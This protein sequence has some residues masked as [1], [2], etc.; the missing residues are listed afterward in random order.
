M[1]DHQASGSGGDAK[2]RHLAP[3]GMGGLLYVHI[4]TVREAQRGAWHVRV[5]SLGSGSSGNA[6]LVQTSRTA[7]LVD[8][9]FQPRTLSSRLRQAGV[10]PAMLSAILL[11][12]EHGD[13]AGGAAAFAALYGVPLVSDPRTLK[14][15]LTQQGSALQPVAATSVAQTELAVGRDIKIADLAVRSFPVSHDAV[16][17]CGYVLS[18]GAWT[19]VVVTDTGECIP[20]VV[21]ALRGAHLLVLEANHDKERL[22]SGPYP[23][24]LKRRILGSTGH[25]SNEQAAEALVQALDEGPRWIWLAHLSRTNNTPDLA[26]RQVRDYL[27]ARGLGHARLQVAPPGIGPQ[28]DSTALLNATPPLDSSDAGHP[29]DTAVSP[30]RPREPRT[31]V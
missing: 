31:E 24:H 25:L 12:H 20:P 26:R 8:A 30:A 17:P 7:V 18:T 9:G 6:L 4:L 2:E 10:T 27:W 11:T 16:A 3:G 23:W 28:W 22:L 1:D 21:E 13:H 15:V 29:A 19:V 5:V 14:Q